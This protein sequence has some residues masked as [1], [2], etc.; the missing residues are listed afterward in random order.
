MH[1]LDSSS[2]DLQYKPKTATVSIAFITYLPAFVATS[3][4]S[5]NQN[6]FRFVTVS[7]TTFQRHLDQDDAIE[8]LRHFRL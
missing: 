8:R 3:S 4:H 5:R 1:E 6:D 2:R 7:V